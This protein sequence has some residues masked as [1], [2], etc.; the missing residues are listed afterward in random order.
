LNN[1]ATKEGKIYSSAFNAT[2]IITGLGFFV[3]SF[4]LFLYNAM[5]VAALSELGFAGDELTRIGIFIINLQITGA[6]IGSVV[7]G[8]IGDR[9][10]RKSGL[11]WSILTY[12]IGMLFT[13]AATDSSTLA[14]GRFLAGFGAAGEI[15]LGATLVAETVKARHRTFSLAFF[16]LMGTLG[17]TAAALSL[18]LAHWRTCC[19]VGAAAGIC[20]LLFR[21]KLFESPLFEE[22]SINPKGRGSL[23]EL[24]LVPKN[25]WSLIRCTLVLVPNFFVIGVLLTLS[26]EV[27]R[28]ISVS[29]PVKANIALASYFAVSALGDLFGAALSNTFS[30]RRLVAGLFVVA[31]ISMVFVILSSQQVS[32]TQF[33]ML[34]AGMGI[35]N[36]WAISGTITVEHFPTHLRSL[37]SSVSCNLARGSVVVMNLALLSLKPI[38]IIQAL[39]VISAVVALL[40]TLSILKIRE[41]FGRD[42]DFNDN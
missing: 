29:S 18:E 37:A 11:V 12:S 36:L 22:C 1:S 2:V 7:F 28:A 40:G 34:C 4:D 8:V 31:N 6:L 10:G 17:V 35:F 25:V 9:V 26:P 24:L 27:A 41:T 20:L 33:Y 19:F 32:A 38:G 23:R 39:L 21:I 42:L 16:T 3:D 14:L 5:R 30:S 15:G 13:A